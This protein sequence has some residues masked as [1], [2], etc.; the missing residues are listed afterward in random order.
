MQKK[1]EYAPIYF[2]KMKTINAIKEI[3]ANVDNE[4]DDD[5]QRTRIKESSVISTASVTSQSVPRACKNPESLGESVCRS[6]PLDKSS[7]T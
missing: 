7:E 4:D 3:T 5:L 6:H 1:R 2:S